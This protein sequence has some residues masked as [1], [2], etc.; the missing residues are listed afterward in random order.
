LRLGFVSSRF[1]GVVAVGVTASVVCLATTQP[2]SLATSAAELAALIVEGSSTNQSGQGIPD[3]FDGKFQ[4]TNTVIVNFLTGPFGI[5]Q[6][7]K[8]NQQDTDNVVLSSGWGAANAS[9]LASILASTDPNNPALTKTSWI[10]DNNVA[11]PNGGFGTRYPVFALIGVNPVPPP[12]NTGA[13]IVSIVYEYDINSNSPKYVLN[14][15][16]DANTLVAYFERRLTQQHLQIP[17]DAQGNPDPACIPSCVQSDGT[18]VYV[19]TVDGVTYVSY[20]A[21]GGLPLVQPLRAL[22]GPGNALA[23]ALEPALTALVNWGYP[24]N[25]PL[26][27]PD[28]LERVGLFPGPSENKKFVTDFVGGVENGLATLNPPSTTS[29]VTAAQPNSLT[30]AQDPAPIKAKPAMNVVRQGPKFVPGSLKPATT[31]TASKPGPIVTAIK[32]AFDNLAKAFTPQST[33]TTTT[34]ST[35]STG[36]ATP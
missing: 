14:P 10:L 23:D 30:V 18:T 31:T 27:N 16:A 22:G 24:N 15:V 21:P 20:E 12:T 19:S 35:A 32:T 11:A 5:Y 4:Q 17:V 26:A 13:N 33:T 8:D 9:A 3:F 7:L 34:D 29:S 28:K 1:V 36:E 6:A 25:D 2:E